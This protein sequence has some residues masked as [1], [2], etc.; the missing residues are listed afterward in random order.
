MLTG[1]GHQ[2]YRAVHVAKFFNLGCSTLLEKHFSLPA[3]R[4]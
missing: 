3:Q 4:F 1:K 2:I